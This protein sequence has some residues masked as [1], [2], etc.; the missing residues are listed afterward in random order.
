MDKAKV[1]EREPKRIFIF[2]V[3]FISIVSCLFY[4]LYQP[5]SSII[6]SFGEFHYEH[7]TCIMFFVNTSKAYYFVKH[8]NL[9]FKPEK[10]ISFIYLSFRFCYIYSISIV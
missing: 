3:L 1:D 7:L 4:L 9:Y 5:E 2:L 10:H 6:I 8:F